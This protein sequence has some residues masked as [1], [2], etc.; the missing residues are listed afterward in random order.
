[1]RN[2]IANLLLVLGTVFG[3]LAAAD[4]KRV[5]RDRP[6]SDGSTLVGARLFEPVSLGGSGGELA[7]DVEITPEV[8]DALIAAGVERVRVRHPKRSSETLSVGDALLGRV[9]AEPVV[10]PGETESFRAGR[11]VTPELR[12]RAEAA[13]VPLPVEV[14]G[15]PDQANAKEHLSSS[16]ELPAR[17]RRDA[18]VD[19]DT[20]ARLERAKVGTVEVRIP[21]DFVL[22]EWRWGWMFALALVAMAGGVALKR[23]RAAG[24]AAGS[25]RANV[26]AASL[27]QRF[28]AIER[29]LGALEARLDRLDARALHAAIDSLLT[30]P[31]YRFVEDREALRAAHGLKA[32]ALVM[33]PFA[34][35]ERK[36]NRA[37]S[38]A[39]D[40][41]LD[42]ARD[43]VRGALPFLRETASAFAPYR[44]R[45]VAP[46]R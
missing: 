43:C 23:M 18:Y 20:L 32:Q 9:L 24:G 14:E 35:V 30:G 27:A 29:E 15:K 2:G 31:V 3:A 10:L 22:A 44:A 34:G 21:P 6:L 38:A 42:E 4:S 7:P 11:I 13:G 1:M 17:L 37:W 28:D 39:V 12:Q 19:R 5:Y 36:L 33:A 41:D 16:I 46:A 8:L 25:E 45:A 26:G 40:G